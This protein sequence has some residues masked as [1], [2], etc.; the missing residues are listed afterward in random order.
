M[1]VL[2]EIIEILEAAIPANPESAQNK[3]LMKAFENDLKGYFK[4]L[5]ASMPMKE[6]EQIYNQYAE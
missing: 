2:N 6:L 3:R 1:Q 4:K 5:E